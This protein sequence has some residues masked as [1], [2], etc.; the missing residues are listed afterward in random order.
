MRS[1]GT[2]EGRAPAPAGLARLAVP[3][4][5]A[6][7]LGLAAAALWH[8]VPPGSAAQLEPARVLQLHAAR[9]LLGWE[10][11]PGAPGSVLVRGP[12]GERRVDAQPAQTAADEQR[13]W[14]TGLAPATPY[15]YTVLAG[16][17]VLHRGHFVTA[18]DDARPFTAVVFGDSGKGSPEQRAL[19]A[20]I[21]AA[22]PDLV[23]HTGDVLYLDDVEEAFLG[24]YAPLLARI[25]F[26]PATGNHDLEHAQG[27]ARLF[28]LP[29]NGPPSLPP[30]RSYWFDHGSARIAVVDS[31][32]G[33]KTLRYQIGS[34]LREVFAPDAGPRWRFVVLHHPPYTFGGHEDTRPV[35]A[36]LVPIF[37]ELGVDAVFSGHDHNYQRTAPLWQGHEAVAGERG[38]VYVVTGGGGGSLDALQPRAS[39][40]PWLRAGVDAQH[41]FTHLEVGPDGLEG[42]Q[43]G[44]DGRVLD[45]WSLPARPRH[46]VAA[47]AAGPGTATAGPAGPA[48]VAAD[49]R[50]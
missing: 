35:K 22:A 30:G 33:P 43:V 3:V 40:P 48:R 8:T 37:E 15:A 17:E 10:A 31:N 29:A 4:A 7:L 23:L 25:A 27:F 20:R 13:A 32:H 41:S 9:A 1:D 26:W 18:P 34:W 21:E 5:V 16:D 39:W 12:R 38:V 45:R 6:L 24:P 44:A 42:R 50:P 49:A 14:L 19:A 2:I 11:A 47:R 46:A 28:D 36:S